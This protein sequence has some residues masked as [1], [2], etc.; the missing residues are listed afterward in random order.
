MQLSVARYLTVLSLTTLN[1]HHR[2]QTRGASHHGEST[3][4]GIVLLP[5]LNR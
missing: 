1:S 5:D 4:S 3:Y 2:T